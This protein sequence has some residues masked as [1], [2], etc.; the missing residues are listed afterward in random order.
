MMAQAGDGI[1]VVPA[2]GT[3]ALT[4]LGT[5]PSRVSAI[6]LGGIVLNGP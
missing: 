5:D 2:D 3:A 6:K 1:G 4:P